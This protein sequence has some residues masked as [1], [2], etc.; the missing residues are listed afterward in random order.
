MN[1]GGKPPTCRGVKSYRKKNPRVS[2]WLAVRIWW[3]V[4]TQQC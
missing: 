2:M 3:E 4:A 1:S